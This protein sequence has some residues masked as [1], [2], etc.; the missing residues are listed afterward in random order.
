MVV[1]V[2]VCLSAFLFSVHLNTL[3]S[4][5]SVY[6]F[7]H[8]SI[9]LFRLFYSYSFS[10]SFYVRQFI[11]SVDLF[12][13]LYICLSISLSLCLFIHLSIFICSVSIFALT[14]LY[15]SILVRV[16]FIYRLHIQY[17]TNGV[18]NAH[19]I[20]M[21]LVSPT[22]MPDIIFFSKAF[23]TNNSHFPIILTISER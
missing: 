5:V 1:S 16:L 20:N 12:I 7:I 19:Y 3:L 15:F 17:S 2:Y 4:I 21:I 22:D 6:L 14:T 9:H 23:S 11:L 18:F 13:Y 10:P 8:L